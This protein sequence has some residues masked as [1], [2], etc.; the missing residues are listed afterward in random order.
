MRQRWGLTPHQQMSPALEDRLAYFVTATTA[1]EPAAQLARKVGLPL[2]A[3]RLHALTQRLG[4]RALTQTQARQATVP[5]EK[6]PLRAA[7]PL[8]VLLLDGFQVR[9]RG[10]GWGRKK[11]LQNRVEWHEQKIGVYYRHEQS[12]PGVLA[13]KVVVSGQG[14]P[15]ELSQRLHWE[16][17]RH[18]LNRARALLALGDGADWIW[19]AVADRWPAAHQLL[20]FYHASE[21]VWSLGEACQREAPA[22]SR[23][24]ETQLHQLRHGQEKRVLKRLAALPRQRGERG[25]NQRREQNY[26]AGHAHRLNYGAVAKRGWPI[27]S[28]AVESACR[29]KQ[30]RFKNCGQFWSPEGLARLNALIEARDLHH[31]DELWSAN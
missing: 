1:Y 11:T 29:Q 26:L 14:P 15:L 30:V 20:D 17:Q 27:G 28:G 16:A 23:W 21:H 9:Q 6:E 13:E 10:P 25:R 4:Q 7:S 12:A 31:W 3:G 18:G 19:R 24:V 2:D 5:A 8:G 22:R